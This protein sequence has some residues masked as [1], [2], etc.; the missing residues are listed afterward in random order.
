MEH[1]T[2]AVRWPP[3]QRPAP[4]GKPESRRPAAASDR[5]RNSD[6]RRSQGPAVVRRP[7]RPRFFLELL[8]GPRDRDGLPESLRFWKQIEPSEDPTLSVGV[9]PSQRLRKSSLVKA[10]LLPRLARRAPR[11]RRGDAGG[12]RD[13]PAQGRGGGS[14]RYLMIPI[15]R[16]VHA[17]LRGH[18]CPPAGSAARPGPVRAV[19]PC[20]AGRSGPELTR[21]PAV[22]WRTVQAIVTSGMTSGSPE[23]VPARLEIEIVEGDNV[24]LVDLFDPDPCPEGADRVRAGVRVPRGGR[25][26]GSG[27]FSHQDHDGPGPGR[28]V[29]SVPWPCSPNGPRAAWSPAT[30]KEVGG[31]EGVGLAFLEETFSR[32][33]PSEITKRRPRPS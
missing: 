18:T 22:R 17:A 27:D 6:R 13:P 19:A 31:T 32:G 20:P 8:P 11:L 25:S 33:R 4:H 23:P 7:Q 5:T 24:T 14:P 30:L 29:I 26:P 28:R 21:H 10:G 1:G 3:G 15:S 9:I 16:R 2:G 12:D